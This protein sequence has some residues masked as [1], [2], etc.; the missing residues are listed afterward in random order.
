MRQVYEAFTP[1]E[2]HFLRGLLESH[3]VEAEVRGEALYSIR[4]GVPAAT[5]TLPTLWILNDEDFEKAREVVDGYERRDERPSSSG[6]PW[7]CRNC[8][9]R[10]EGQFTSCWNCGTERSPTGGASE[11]HGV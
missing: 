9:E 6:F 7:T 11:E 2:A 4:G 5:E 10:V 3:G 8:G 1:M